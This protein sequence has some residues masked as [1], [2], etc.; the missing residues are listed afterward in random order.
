M[1]GELF[2]IVEKLQK[3]TKGHIG[4]NHGLEDN[5]AQTQSLNLVAAFFLIM[6]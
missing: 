6:K 1:Q 5:F 3:L 4:E 2:E